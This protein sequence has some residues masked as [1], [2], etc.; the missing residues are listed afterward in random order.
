[1]NKMILLFFLFCNVELVFG[2][3]DMA[4][5]NNLLDYYIIDGLHEDNS[6]IKVWYTAL[7]LLDEYDRGQNAGFEI[8][9]DC[10]GK[11][12]SAERGS[13]WWEYYF[14]FH[15][16]GSSDLCNVVRVPRYK[17]SILRFK[18]A[19]AMTPERG[20]YLINEY[21][22]IQPT[23][24]AKLD[25]IQQEYWPENKRIVGIFYQKP[26]MPE[27][28]LSW[29][30]AILCERVRQ[31]IKNIEEYK[32]ILFSDLEDF[33]DEFISQFGSG[34]VRIPCLNNKGVSSP[35]ECG[36]HELLTLLL[37]AQCH[38]VIA[39]GSYQGIGAQMLNPKLQLI[40][41]DAFPYAI[42]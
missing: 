6:V 38:I 40:E 16:V 25:R 39:P 26:I 17:R 42:K 9:F 3:T 28:Q 37:L 5:T 1:M 31:E 2:K 7:G 21:M 20:N 27:V 30:P 15:E 18:T 8:L 14:S 35:A 34:C 33:A 19:C 36:E 22:H 12:Y 10:N 29:D 4:S 11:H 13:N 23:I 24:K 32:C 41:F